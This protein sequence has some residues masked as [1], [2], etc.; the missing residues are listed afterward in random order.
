MAPGD[1]ITA[2]F[3]VK[4]DSTIAIKYRAKVE[5]PDGTALTADVT[6]LKDKWT[7]V[8]AGAELATD[9]VTLVVELPTTATEGFEEA[10]TIKLTV[11]AVQANADVTDS[12]VADGTQAGLVKLIDELPAADEEGQYTIELP[13]GKYEVPSSS[14][15]KTEGKEIVIKGA[16]EGTSLKVTSST[17]FAEGGNLIYDRDASFVFENMSI[18]GEG[19]SVNYGGIVCDK[20]TYKNCVI[21]GKTHL[22]GSADF[23]NCTFIQEEDEYS[24]YT[25]GANVVNVESCRFRSQCKAI[26]LYGNNTTVL[27]IKNSSFT[28]TVVDKAVVEVG[29]ESGYNDAD[30]TLNITNCTETGFADGELVKNSGNTTGSHWYSDAYYD[31]N[32]NTPMV[33]TIDGVEVYRTPK[34]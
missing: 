30:Y 17:V 7:S 10:K 31:R 33:V 21:Y 34:A 32:N 22:Y 27:N 16:G 23:I 4:N 1:K 25:W 26:K 3:T 6:G 28:S 8:E 20:V 29:K 18:V 13:D 19:K 5:L 14:D 15:A 12:V 2:A 24:F 9:A 11:E